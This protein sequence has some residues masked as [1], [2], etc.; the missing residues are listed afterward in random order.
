MGGSKNSQIWHSKKVRSLDILNIINIKVAE[1]VKEQPH[2][3]SNHLLSFKSIRIEK[4]KGA[5]HIKFF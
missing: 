1:F 3:V 4:E 2:G 5:S